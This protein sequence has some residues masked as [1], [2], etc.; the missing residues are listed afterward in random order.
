MK[1]HY[2]EKLHCG[3]FLINY[4]QHDLELIVLTDLSLKLLVGMANSRMFY[5][6]YILKHFTSFMIT[7]KSQIQEIIQ[8]TVFYQM[9][10]YT[11]YKLMILMK[12]QERRKSYNMLVT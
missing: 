2:S 6:R 10:H 3:E 9:L 1:K 4:E 5:N 8:S 11:N 7:L 12:E